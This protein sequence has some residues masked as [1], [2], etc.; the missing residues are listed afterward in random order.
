MRLETDFKSPLQRRVDIAQE[1]LDAYVGK[2]FA[3]GSADCVRL[4]V[5]V[6]RKAGFHPGLAKFGEYSSEAGARRALRHA[7]MATL[8]D[9]VDD[10][11]LM[12]IA[13]ASALP[14]DLIAFPGEGE[15]Q[16]LAVALGNRRVLGFTESVQDGACSIIA[17][18]LEHAITAWS[19][20]PWR[21]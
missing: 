9:A 7:K 19:V 13:P 1:A 3:W 8:A 16:G 20:P 11:G 2:P 12:R 14:C 6:L 10:V 18:N 21:K 17:A 5:F 15:L 4:A